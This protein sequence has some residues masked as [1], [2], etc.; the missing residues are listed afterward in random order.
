MRT[1]SLSNATADSGASS[2][3][4]K[5][6]TVVNNENKKEAGK[7][8]KN[9]GKKD[10]EN[11]NF[12][13]NGD[14]GNFS[15]KFEKD[16]SRG[17]FGIASKRNSMLSV[18]NLNNLND[19]NNLKN[20]NDSSIYDKNEFD[21]DV[22]NFDDETRFDRSRKC[23]TSSQKP[24]RPNNMKIINKEI[25]T[26]DESNTNL[27]KN[28]DLSE[29]GKR[30]KADFEKISELNVKSLHHI[31]D[32]KNMQIGKNKN[33]SDVE[34]VSTVTS[35]KSKSS[36]SKFKS[37]LSHTVGAK[38]RYRNK[39]KGSD[40]GKSGQENFNEND[41]QI[42]GSS[43]HS[44]YS[45][46]KKSNPDENRNGNDHE[47]GD[48]QSVDKRNSVNPKSA[49]Y[50]SNANSPE[51]KKWADGSNNE[52]YNY[53][54][55]KN[56]GDYSKSNKI[57]EEIEKSYY[58]RQKNVTENILNDKNK[59]SNQNANNNKGSLSRS[60]S[61][62]KFQNIGNDEKNKTNDKK[63]SSLNKYTNFFRSS[64]NKNIDENSSVDSDRN[65][66]ENKK[67][68]KNVPL[69]QKGRESPKFEVYQSVFSNSYQNPSKS[70]TEKN[71][72]TV[73]H[74]NYVEEEK[75]KINEYSFKILPGI[76]AHTNLMKN[77]NSD[78]NR[79]EVEIQKIEI[80]EEK[81]IEKEKIRMDRSKQMELIKLRRE[82]EIEKETVKL[83]KVDYGYDSHDN[84]NN[85]DNGKKHKQSREEEEGRRYTKGF[86]IGYEDDDQN[87]ES[88]SE[89]E[90]E[91]DEDNLR[92]SRASFSKKDGRGIIHFFLLFL[93]FSSFFM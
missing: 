87:D 63:R 28:Q 72:T 68:E 80:E 83:P 61:D 50:S 25:E 45:W 60:S 66:I 14:D 31:G 64:K 88:E 82:G 54:K 42:S 59:I 62:G 26:Y 22:S 3:S 90:N 77:E 18:G 91:N 19:S 47:N 7:N 67:V 56:I 75:T 21:D 57:E 92:F 13:V 2:I 4:R 43:F 44:R 78:S 73:H 33:Y 1:R 89:N 71:D 16:F 58:E 51:N 20:E 74:G 12:D 8:T 35:K 15:S 29:S 81:D 5:D 46:S 17:E 55:N 6:N 65:K 40:N 39:N 76:E 36:W 52:N 11:S 84:D 38:S 23:S 69:N 41:S 49:N 37:T 86:G 9:D 27:N 70:S 53:N 48:F 93:H 34:S 79:C 10:N 30:Q 85:S 24:P 32:I